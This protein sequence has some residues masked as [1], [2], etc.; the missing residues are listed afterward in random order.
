LCLIVKKKIKA[1]GFDIDE[2]KIKKL[3]NNI[4]YISD[5][6]SKDL[7]ILDKKNLYSL[8]NISKIKNCNFIIFCLPTPLT[9]NNAPDVSIIKKSF[10][11]LKNYLVKGQTIILESTVYPGATKDIFY[12]FLVKRFKLDKNFFYGYSSERISPGQTNKKFYKIKYQDITKVISG[13]GNNSTN[14]IFKFYSE[15][16]KKIFI[17]KNIEVAEMSKLLE[18]A[19]R[20][21]NIGLVNEL[22]VICEKIS[23][24]INAVID[25]ASTKPFGFN[26]FRP[27]PGVGGHCIPIDPVF[28]SWVAKKNNCSARFIELARKTNL[29]ITQW[30]INKITNIINK[31]YNSLNIRILIIGISYKPDVN[32]IRESP[33]VNIFLNLYKKFYKVEF[34][35]PFVPFFKEGRTKF[36]SINNLSGINKYDLILILTDHSKLNYKNILKKSN[37]VVDTRGVYKNLK[38]EKIINL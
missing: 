9:K 29:N 13:H 26:T 1:L 5:I 18:N 2:K 25:A 28:I 4:S 15:I 22:K 8:K 17:A 37:L 34:Y 12:N 21:V 27:G 20:A 6:N 30:T 16:F 36:Y 33:S 24:D 35:D 10:H 23:L 19:Y 14:K 3:K 38:S 11:K 7:R 31:K 32:D